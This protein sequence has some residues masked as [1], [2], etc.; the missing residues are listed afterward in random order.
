MTEMLA[1]YLPWAAFVAPD[2]I[3]CKHGGLLAVIRFVPPDLDTEDDVQLMGSRAR[4]SDI[5]S[6]LD[7]RWA[8]WLD[9]RRAP[10]GD[11]LDRVEWPC[12]AAR[13]VDDERRAEFER[14]GQQFRDHHHL[15]LVMMPP[16][17]IARLASYV[18][19]GESV[20]E[21]AR[22]QLRR[23]QETIGQ[24]MAMLAGV[25]QLVDRLGPDTLL[26]Y[27][28]STISARPGQAVRAVPAWLD[29]VLADSPLELGRSPTLG[30]QHLR[31][32]SVRHMPAETQPRMLEALRALPFAYRWTVRWLSMDRDEARTMLSRTRRRWNVLAKNLGKM[33]GEAIANVDSGISV[34]TT[35]MKADLDEAEAEMSLAGL[36]YGYVTMTISLLAPT[37]EAA[38][39]R[40]D[41]VAGAL[42]SAGFVPLIERRGIADAWLGAVP[43]V[44][45]ADIRRV[46]VQ[47]LSLCDMLP[48]AGVSEGAA[49]D[50]HLGGSAL[51]V[52]Q[53]GS[54][55]PAYFALHSPGQDVGHTAIIG[56]TGSGKSALMSLMALQFLRYPGAQ[57]IIVDR[58]RSARCMT[59]CAG[60]AWLDL[61]SGGLALQPLRHVDEPAERAWAADW[62]IK[63]M[64]MRGVVVTPQTELEID[65]ALRLIA[66]EDPDRRT[67]TLLAALLGDADHR[68]VVLG[69]SA[70][71]P[72]GALLDGVETDAI[73]DTPIISVEIGD[74]LDRE[75]GGLVLLALFHRLRR[76]R[77]DGRPTLLIVDEA[78]RALKH[79]IFAGWL[80]SALREMRKWN[81]SVVVATQSVE[82]VTTGPLA[83]ALEQVV[84]RIWLPNARALEPNIAALYRA[85]GV[86]DRMVEVIAR[87]KPKC[88]MILQTPIMVRPLSLPFGP[89]QKRICGSSSPRDHE[90]M[91]ALLRRP[92]GGPFIERWTASA[93]S[94][95]TPSP[96][97]AISGQPS[98]P[99]SASTPR[100][101]LVS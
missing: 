21:V 12:E 81:T 70:A 64:V 34:A 35:T 46:P 65:A 50:T 8:A 84:N 63:A 36:S 40:A 44:L 89:R 48:V 100:G 86:G 56:P 43:G 2:V 45:G 96:T 31:V 57:A 55:I 71:G 49:R 29:R 88:D 87:S 91:D 101:R 22:A 79:E 97:R 42:A 68:A 76:A 72:H 80:G 77:I 33:L 14:A 39:E 16:A 53:T 26:G 3:G 69:M 78:W 85:T 93:S 90:A 83:G 54:R 27:L 37:A 52:G 98:R 25:M 75:I 1:Q 95:S 38:T 32:V 10:A 15:T 82:D 73:A 41:A 92:S 47:S 99:R 20:D 58:G 28:H 66:D 24:V 94:T 6:R 62:L 61:P 19:D 11:Y 60:G 9:C 18:A 7:G 74:I 4:L 17:R 13:M 59:L 30:D 51:L 5:V 23:F 67:L